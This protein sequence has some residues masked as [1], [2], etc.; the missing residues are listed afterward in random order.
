MKTSEKIIKARNE[1]N[2]TQDQLAELL[3]VSRQ[4]ISKW[5]LDI[6]LPDTSRLL[7]LSQLL[8]VSVD[9]LLNEDNQEQA[10]KVPMKQGESGVE[11]DWTE[12]YPIL[13]QYENEVDCDYYCKKFNRIFDELIN[14]HQYSQEDAM[15]VAKELLAKAYFRRIEAAQK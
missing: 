2:Y 6:S 12:L 5:E 11:P 4:T 13:K 3:N 9:Y 8:N 15:L 1:M 7:K 14:A 10:V